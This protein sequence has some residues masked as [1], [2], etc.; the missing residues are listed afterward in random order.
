M[1]YRSGKALRE[2]DAK[3]NQARTLGV[4]ALVLAVCC[5]A[6]YVIPFAR[7]AVFWVSFAFSILAILIQFYVVRRV[8]S[9]GRAPRKT[10]SGISIDQIGLTYLTLQLIVCFVFLAIGPRLPIWVAVVLY[11]VVLHLAVICIAVLDNLRTEKDREDEDGEEEE[12]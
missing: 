11:V 8:F 12:Q 2:M 7:G 1:L 3:K 9:R 6:V 10:A 5:A 4:L